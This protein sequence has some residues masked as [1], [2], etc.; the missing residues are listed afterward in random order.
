MKKK[1][2]HISDTTVRQLISQNGNE[3]EF[4]EAFEK[5][6]LGRKVFAIVHRIA[7]VTGEQLGIAFK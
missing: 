3:P 7:K 2:R 6:M 1:N 5:E 4:V